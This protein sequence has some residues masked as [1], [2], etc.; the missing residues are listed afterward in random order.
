VADRHGVTS[1]Q[2]SLAWILAQGPNVVPIPGT[3]RRKWLDENA[4]A[5]EVILTA[6]DLSEIA[7]LPKPIAPRY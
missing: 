4:K 7:S 1:A 6:Q 2:I 5:G 3:K